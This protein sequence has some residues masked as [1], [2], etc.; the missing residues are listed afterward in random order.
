MHEVKAIETVYN[1]YRFRSRLEARWAVFFD[2]LEIEYRYEDEGFDLDGTWYLPDF[3]L[4]EQNCFIEIKGQKPTPQENARAF[5]LTEYK[6]YPVFLFS[7]SIDPEQEA[8]KFEPTLW[9]L[10]GVDPISPC[11]Y[12][13]KQEQICARGYSIFWKILKGTIN[14]KECQCSSCSH[15]L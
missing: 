3:W 11:E 13:S 10:G 1:G 4:P 7:G 5:S 6:G 9:Y 14:Y 12:I 2:T 8:I 15:H